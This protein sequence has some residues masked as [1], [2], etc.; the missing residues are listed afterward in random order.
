MISDLL[1]I[2]VLVVF[3]TDLSGWTDSWR[4]VAQRA[5]RL[6][7]GWA[8]DRIR[9]FDCSQCMTWW[10]CII[11]LLCHGN[12]TLLSAACSA[13]LALLAG[14]VGQL[15]LALYDAVTAFIHMIQKLTEHVF[16]E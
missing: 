16:H 12:L 1:C 9:P 2:C 10:C 3:V 4:P 6:W 14:P 11:W 15:L 5:L 7:L 8:P 13:V